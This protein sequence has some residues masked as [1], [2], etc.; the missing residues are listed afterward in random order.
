[1]PPL[2]RSR[3]LWAG[4]AAAIAVSIAI[5]ALA[6]RPPP[7]DLTP[8]RLSVVPPSGTAFTARDITGHPQFALSPDGSRLAFVAARQG[9]QPMLWVRS[10]ASGAA[11]PMPG[12]EGAS[13]PFWAPDSQSLAF[14]TRRKLMRVS[15]DGAPP[16]GLAD[17]AI[18]V[19]SGA[20]NTDDVIL[21][22]AGEG[23]FRVP[24]G[25]GP[26]TQTTHLDPTQGETNNRWPQFLPDGRRFLMHV[27]SAT[28]Q[29][30]GVYVSALDTDSKTQLLES[31]ANAV[32]AE[33]GYL[34][35]EQNGSL[36][37]QRFD[38]GS[39]ELS[40]QPIALGDLIL[41]LFGSGYLPL[42]AAQDG[43]LAYWNGTP[44]PTEL[45]WFD[46][47]GRLLST[48]ETSV[49][50]DSLALSPDA[51]RLL[52]TL[53]PNPNQNQIWRFDLSSGVGSQLTFL[54]PGGR[55]GI[56]APDGQSVV[57]GGAGA[58][59][60][61]RPAGGEGQETL[62]PGPLRH[63]A[64]FPEDWSRDNRWLIYSATAK[65][66]WDIWALDLMDH[67]ARPILASPAN[68]V[69]GRLSPDGRWLA[70]TSDES[71]AWEV[72]VQPFPDGAGKWQVSTGGGSQPFWRGDGIELFYLAADGRLIAVALGG[73]P[74]FEPKPIQPLFQ[75][76]VPPML[77]PFRSGYAVSPDGQ[78]FLLNNVVPDAEPSAITI[79]RH[80][81]AGRETRP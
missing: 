18:D 51:T 2:T 41:G 22:A 6:L 58:P 33:P 80:W 54:P 36:V 65:T 47:S 39:G 61:Q 10:L 28:A 56:W 1:M 52:V 25:G 11:Q 27:S 68:E 81:R 57:F 4:A 30:S 69:M 38:P 60:Y 17:I 46:R 67:T 64:I 59:L 5:T 49:R 74:T 62:V 31:R 63:Y 50:S 35:F 55:F 71:G 53:R 43:T 12:T 15:L 3:V 73:G 40:E 23:L 16:R 44:P 20:W 26:V 13:G 70:Y 76:R 19:G 34:L 48:I 24:A 8:L 78:R 42:S 32:Y 77:A 79:V 66:A 29:R 72:Y 45:Q 14:S 9:E 75:T 37:S 21:F 7:A